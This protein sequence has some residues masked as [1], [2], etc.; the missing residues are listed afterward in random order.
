MSDR[1]SESRAVWMQFFRTTSA[2]MQRRT[3]P[4][5]PN[6]KED[7]MKVTCYRTDGQLFSPTNTTQ[8]DTTH[9]PVLLDQRSQENTDRMLIDRTAGHTPTGL[10]Q[11]GHTPTG[12]TP[13]GHTPTGHTPTGHTPIVL[14]DRSRHIRT[15]GQEPARTDLCRLCIARP[16]TDRCRRRD[17]EA[18]TSTNRTTTPIETISTNV[19]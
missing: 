2:E 1:Q 11:T 16:P 12:H 15:A 4:S 3:V 8:P 9:R 10:T 5:W 19:L 7:P 14:T 18:S 13:T 6:S 17:R